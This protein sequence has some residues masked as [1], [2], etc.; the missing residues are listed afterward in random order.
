MIIGGEKGHVATFD[1]QTGKLN[2]ELQLRELVRDVTWLHN[3]TMFAVA[4]RKYAYIYDHTGAEIHCLKKHVEPTRLSFLPYHFLLASVGIPGNLIYQD[5]ST[6]DVVAEHR[7]RLGRCTIME[8]NPWNGVMH[9][10]HN[11]GTVT[12]WS[13]SQGTPLVKMLCHKG[14]V[15][16]MAID[17]TG[18]H[19]VTAGLDGQMRVWDIRNFRSLHDYYTPRPAKCLDIS[20]N[21]LISVGYGSTVTV[22]K[23]GLERKQTSPYMSHTLSGASGRSVRAEDVRFCPYEDVLGIGHSGGIS[24]VV[25]PG[26]GE[27][28]YDSMEAN[29]YQTAKQRQESEVH[30]L[31]EKIQPGLIQLEPNFIGRLD[32]P[33]QAVKDQEAEEDAEGKGKGKSDPRHRAKGKSSAMRKWLRKKNRNVIDDRMVHVQEA[34]KA[35][36]EQ[37]KERKRAA[38]EGVILDTGKEGALSGF[39]ASMKKKPKVY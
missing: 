20:Q 22:W 17:R 3:E 26:A 29:P 36:K 1:W 35:K 24:S 10:G 39:Y 2:A 28:N 8:Q 4:Q 15:S 13:P 6:G 32:K 11:N 38:N 25:I 18:R 23:E 12:L 27:A 9:L 33:S 34:L 31:M 16:A 19:M 5:T 37:A 30:S 14:P 21:G 7:T